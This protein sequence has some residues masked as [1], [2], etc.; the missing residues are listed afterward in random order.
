MQVMSSK[1]LKKYLFHLLGW[2]CWKSRRGR[3]SRQP[4]VC[5]ALVGRAQLRPWVLQVLLYWQQE[6][7]P[8]PGTAVVRSLCLP[9]LVYLC[10]MS[11][12]KCQEKLRIT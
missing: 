12:W 1:K 6:N 7:T 8:G 11:A 3:G 2:L 5:L 10:F 4:W 9:F